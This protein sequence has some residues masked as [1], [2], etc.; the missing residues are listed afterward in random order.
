MTTTSEQAGQLLERSGDVEMLTAA[1]AA[2]QET[3]KGQLV[4]VGGE[5]GVGKTALLR[6]FCDGLTGRPR[7]LWGACDALFT[8]RPLG[9]LSEIAEAVGG[10][11]ERLVECGAKPYEV[12]AELVHELARRSP[13]VLVLE[14]LHWA[15]EA[16]LDVLRLLAR[17]SEA[18]PALILASYRDD[19][20]GQ[21]QPLR[22]VIG[23]LA[24]SSATRRLSLAPLSREAVASMA[25][26]CLVDPVELYERTGGNPFYVTEVLAAAGKTIPPTVRDAVLARAVRL[27]PEARTVLYAVA[28]VPPQAELWLLEALCA[29]QTEQLEECVDSGMLTTEAGAVTFRHELGRLAIEESIP[30]KLRLDLHRRAIAALTEPPGGVPDLARLAHH[31]DAAGDVEAV[32]RF[33]PA[34]ATRS[35]LLGAHR[36]AAAQYARALRFADRLP[37]DARADLLERRA[38]ECYLTDQYDEGIAALEEALEYRRALG[39]RLKEGDA[40]QRLS[41]FL[42]CPGRTAEAERAARKAV[43]LLEVLPP[44]TE[45]AWAYANLAF[46]CASAMRSDEA[47]TWN[48][49]ALSLA[50]RF[51]DDE[52][53]TH[54]LAGLV[55]SRRDD[56][57]LE[58]CQERARQAGR[59]EQVA[60]ISIALSGLAVES[61]RHAAACRY[62][63]EGI[64]LCS[65]RGFELFR[66]YL[67]PQRARLELD[68]GQWSEAA[69][70]AAMVLRIPRTSTTPRIL[71]LTV[72]ALVRARRGDPEVWPL[73]DEAWALAEPTNELPRL[74]PVAAARAEAAWLDGRPEVIAVETEAAFELALLRQVPWLAGELACW[75]RRAGLTERL[76]VEVPEPYGLELAGDRVAAAEAWTR[77]DCPYDAALALA[78]ADAPEAL[79]SALDQFNRVEARPAAAIVTRRL[80]ELG[81]RRLPRG[82]RAATRANVAGLTPRELEVLPLVV[83]G[84]RNSEIAARLFV[85]EKTVDHHVS[86]ILRKLGVQT[87]GQA[88]AEAV[89]LGLVTTRG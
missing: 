34:A 55:G 38:N 51:G 69:E 74:G 18:V 25:E 28:A 10:E 1:V 13:T 36:E 7:V 26:P 52:L 64:A 23:E 45:L 76:G 17:R 63:E 59:D 50:E 85:S 83:E 89:R 46:I 75:R 67:L 30:V 29:C 60:G 35:R 49:R 40:L 79:R 65:E 47:I 53:A 70:S 24:A 73:L 87:R 20:L 3:G 61:R 66:L 80:R 86:A 54:A 11:L 62:L 19:V 44:G 82:P 32:L 27:S 78:H 88:G 4:F 8:P 58:Q 72:L 33:A 56:A 22:I 5:A 41:N 57:L 12:V 16:T 43:A 81:V 6:R 68:Q 71:A 42:W 15:D 84:L 31:A 39:D 77:L 37:A 2:V 48:E 9:A 21:A 14:D